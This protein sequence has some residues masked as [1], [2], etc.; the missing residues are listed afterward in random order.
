MLPADFSTADEIDQQ[1][2]QSKY[3]LSKDTSNKDTETANSAVLAFG[4]EFNL[5]LLGHL[6]L[7]VNN[8]SIKT[9][10]IFIFIRKF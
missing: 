2:L 1:C 7:N 10:H 4:F 5:E 6:F 9:P 8:A 3:S